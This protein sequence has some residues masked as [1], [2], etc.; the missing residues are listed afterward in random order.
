MA[1]QIARNERQLGATLRRVR[2]QADLTQLAL[3][4]KVHLRQA[5]RLRTGRSSAQ[6]KQRCRNRG[7]VLM[8]PRGPTYRE[9]SS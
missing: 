1:C 5:T 3:G 9:K 4:N 6:Q 2:R 8:V 7:V